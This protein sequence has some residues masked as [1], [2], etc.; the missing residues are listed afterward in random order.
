MT[1]ETASAAPQ[2][3]SGAV[4]V[5][6]NNRGNKPQKE[7]GL[8]SCPGNKEVELTLNEKFVSSIVCPE[9]GQRFAID[10]TRTADNGSK[11]FTIPQHRITQELHDLRLR[12]EHHASV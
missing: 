11:F 3:K 10:K 12:L 2:K 1:N 5:F 4:R 9:C 7:R 8:P 6:T